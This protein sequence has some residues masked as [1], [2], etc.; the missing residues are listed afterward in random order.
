MCKELSHHTL[1]IGDYTHLLYQTGALKNS[2]FLLKQ[3]PIDC[4][5]IRLMAQ[6]REERGY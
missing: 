4:S 5:F 1:Q 3:I 6:V 2:P